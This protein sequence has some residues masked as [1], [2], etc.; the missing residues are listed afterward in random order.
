M[1]R[2][3]RNLLLAGIFLYIFLIPFFF[4]PDIKIVYYLSQFFL[5]GVV[6]IYEFIFSNTEFGHLG[7]FVY[8]PLA[9]YIFGVLFLPV[10][11][12]AGGGFTQWLAMGNDAVGAR[13]IFS[14]LFAMKLPLVGLH[15][16]TGVFL[17]RLVMG[18]TKRL[19]V[20][21]I[22]FFNPVSIY[23]VGLMGQFDVLPV[24]LTVLA[25]LGVSK[26]PLLSAVAIGLGA[27]IKSYPLFL[28]PFL[29]IT[30][31]K[32]TKKQ[33][34][35]FVTGI[36]VYLAIIAPFVKSQAFY[37]S[38]LVSGLSQRIF[39][40]SLPLGY[41][42]A[43]LI[44]P[45]FLVAL[46]LFAYKKDS[47]NTSRLY[48]YFLA[49]TIAIFVGSHFHPQWAFW[50]IP[51]LTL[52]LV[53]HELKLAAILFF[54]GW[55][56]TVVMFDDIFLSLGLASPIDPGILFL[57][58]PASLIKSV[59]DPLLVQSLFHSLVFTSGLFMIWLGLSK[60]NG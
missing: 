54:I 30:G 37:E 18:E 52:L 23:V 36:A 17:S 5:Q 59:F 4:H 21:A 20:L 16:L 42:E 14:Y 49:A 35:I 46:I 26:K 57:P 25:L 43:I 48:I 31:A 60:K 58:T 40:L 28:L 19:K 53:R 9:Y 27:A 24:F 1:N 51:F 3:Q 41:G 45:A 22:W 39:Q 7:P 56:G 29:A 12:I 47:G 8:P 34:G 55:A 44:V 33:V 50:S 13:N 32:E 6:N 38:T 2:Q 15:V 10:K 11:I